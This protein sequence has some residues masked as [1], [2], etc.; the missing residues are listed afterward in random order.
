MHIS[1]V[2]QCAPQLLLALSPLRS[3]VPPGGLDILV[4]FHYT[5]TSHC[6]TQFIHNSFYLLFVACWPDHYL[7]HHHLVHYTALPN[8]YV[9]SSTTG[10]CFLITPPCA[11]FDSPDSPLRLSP[12]YT[13]TSTVTVP[14]N[15]TSTT[16][17]F[18]KT[19]IGCV[20]HNLPDTFTLI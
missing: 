1:Q 12:T 3:S 11:I 19:C 16:T 20:Y 15:A 18:I 8:L 7:H 5:L 17:S 10:V 6:P 4:W 9:Y 13:V 14:W 2:S